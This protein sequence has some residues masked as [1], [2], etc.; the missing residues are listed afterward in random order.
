[1]HNALLLLTVRLKKNKEISQEAP[2]YCTTR[3]HQGGAMIIS[4]KS[5][6][7][8]DGFLR[9][10]FH[11]LVDEQEEHRRVDRGLTNYLK[12]IVFRADDEQWNT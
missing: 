2:I 1:M 3:Y 4:E 7:F 12:H 9:L 6:C 10:R 5:K 8:D 11:F